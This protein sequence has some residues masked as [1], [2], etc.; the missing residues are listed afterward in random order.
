MLSM[1]KARKYG[2][3][4]QVFFPYSETGW[5][6]GFT[7]LKKNSPLLLRRYI[8]SW[9]ALSECFDELEREKILPSTKQRLAADVGQ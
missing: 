1:N 5:E 8:D 9:D 3:T 2:W 6:G 4:G 7:N